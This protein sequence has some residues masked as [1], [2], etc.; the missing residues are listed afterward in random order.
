[1]KP[2]LR[3]SKAKSVSMTEKSSKLLGEI[4]KFLD[5]CESDENILSDTWRKTLD[6]KGSRYSVGEM[7]CMRKPGSNVSLQIVSFHQLSDAQALDLDN[8]I[9]RALVEMGDSEI[10]EP[11][12]DLNVFDVNISSHYVNSIVTAS[13][14]IAHLDSIGISEPTIMEIGSGIGLLGVALKKWY[15]SKVTLIFSDLPETLEH[16]S[17]LL[18]STFPS[19]KYSFKPSTKNVEIAVGGINFV[20]T[21]KLVSQ[22]YPIDV[23]INCNSMAEMKA[24]TAD[25]YLSY[26]RNNLS[27]NGLI[28]LSNGFGMAT[29]GARTPA[30]Y[31][32]GDGLRV[33]NLDFAD[34]YVYG[35]PTFIFM[36]A[37]LTRSNT[38]NEVELRASQREKYNRFVFLLGSDKAVK[39]SPIQDALKQ[40]SQRSVLDVETSKINQLASTEG[41][42][43]PQ[44][45]GVTIRRFQIAIAT[46][47]NV[48]PQKSSGEVKE[49]IDEAVNDFSE[50]FQNKRAYL[51]EFHNLFFSAAL[52]GLNKD[53]QAS[54]WIK[55][56]YQATRSPYW[57]ARYAW[58]AEACSDLNLSEEILNSIDTDA[59]SR[60]WLPMVANLRFRLGQTDTANSLLSSIENTG[61]VDLAL[62]ELK[63]LFRANC[64]LDN[65]ESSFR[66]YEKIKNLLRSN[67]VVD[68]ELGNNQ[69]MDLICFGVE[70]LKD[71]VIYFEKEFDSLESNFPA[72]IGRMKPLRQ[73]G[74]L[75][76]A[77]SIGHSLEIRFEND[78]FSLAKL[79]ENY[80]YVGDFLSAQRCASNSK[81]LRPDNAKHLKYLGLAFFT[82]GDYE[83]AE[84]HFSELVRNCGED[85]VARGYEA[86]SKLSAEDKVSGI[87]GTADTIHLTFQP[88]QT[89]YYPFGPRAR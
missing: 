47:M 74:R 37:L 8:P 5:E 20:N 71:G 24:E 83:S 61:F 25:A 76:E 80:L 21:Y 45:G 57:L 16:Q 67:N 88:D 7:L 22:N 54:S 50:M 85:F 59:M 49:L 29:G 82:F 11:V 33:E 2:K 48:S 81:I 30:E 63:V 72:T 78:Y 3:V 32:F 62:E 75:K 70:N 52:T 40:L 17:F 1:M 69:L 68:T 36:N 44:L 38:S 41:C 65:R 73:F 87:F 27:S 42:K 84:K 14:I 39:N 89:F 6:L 53:Q 55:D 35:G 51:S 77:I 9:Q 58:V 28:Y 86:F 15:G 46:I 34:G 18:L 10:G 26:A 12:L 43:W 66:L 79:T 13:K 19:E 31:S 64:L 23:F 4:H 56:H 60:S